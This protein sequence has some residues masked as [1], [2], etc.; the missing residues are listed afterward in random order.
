[1]FLHTFYRTFADT[2]Y[3]GADLDMNWCTSQNGQFNICVN[4]ID[5]PT[6][7]PTP[8][9]SPKR[10]PTSAIKN[11]E[12]E[13]E[14]DGLAGWAVALIVIF[15]LLLLACIARALY[16]FY[17]N[18]DYYDDETTKVRNNIYID[19]GDSVYTGKSRGGGKSVR[20][21]KSRRA[22]DDE[23]RS[24]NSQQ[25]VLAVSD[26]ATIGTKK[27]MKS[28]GTRTTK[29][30]VRIP[31]DPT[32]YIPGQE[33]KPDPTV[34]ANDRSSDPE[35]GASS[36]ANGRKYYNTNE[37]PPLKAKRDPTQFVDG[38][39]LGSGSVTTRH[40]Y[41]EDPPLKPKRDPTFF[42]AN[43]DQEDPGVYEP[44]EQKP[45]EGEPNDPN[46]YRAP[47]QQSANVE[48]MYNDDDYI[49]TPP[50]NRDVIEEED[51]EYDQYGFRRSS[52][53]DADDD[54]D[55]QSFRTEEPKSVVSGKSRKSQRSKKSSG[56]GGRSVKGGK[57]RGGK[58]KQSLHST[59]WGES[60]L[61]DTY[62]KD[63]VAE[64]PKS[65]SFY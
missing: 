43:Q 6:P 32:R 41:I 62:A 7:P 23:Q 27:S 29:K 14:N 48:E 13:P 10:A 11:N 39:S 46:V 40:K 50:P 36:S 38:V 33:N 9:P 37:D 34:Y 60:S 42:V 16:V 45:N 1:M 25:L 63:R 31:R 12:S 18:G 58:T 59:S 28:H 21:N 47:S 20:T 52:Q 26:D 30:A 4:E 55:S 64:E 44:D 3:F 51:E 8:V 35:G 5:E 17:I 53:L 65:R 15:V 19:G 24:H 54:N 2:K 49:Y 61:P 56:G 22:I 57:E